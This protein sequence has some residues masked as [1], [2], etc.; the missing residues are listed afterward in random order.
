MYLQS[1]PLALAH[2]VRLQRHLQLS[3]LIQ[4]RNLQVQQEVASWSAKEKEKGK[5]H[6]GPHPHASHD[7]P[8]ESTSLLI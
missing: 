7:L 4:R 3:A 8:F 2:V 5:G 6:Q 1:E